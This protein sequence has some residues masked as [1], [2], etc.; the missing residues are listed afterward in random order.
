MTSPQPR[1]SVIIPAY[2]VQPY[3]AEAVDSALGQSYHDVDVVVVD[4]GSTDG[5]VRVLAQYG[6]GIT[7]V[8]Q[9]NRGLPAARN[10]GIRASTG[11]VVALLDGDDTWL[12]ERVERCV[13]V[14]L[15]R[16]DVGF[17]TTDASLIDA[18][19]ADLGETYCDQVPFP[20]VRF[21]E[22]MVRQNMVYGSPLVRRSVFDAAGPF[23]ETLTSGGED[24]DMWLRLVAAGVAMVTIP[25]PL[26]CYRI[27]RSS[28]TRRD[29]GLTEPRS[30]VL[31]RHLPGFWRRGVYGSSNEAFR[32][33]A[34]LALHGEWKR[35]AEFARAAFRDP[36]RNALEVV[37]AAARSTTR[38]VGSVVARC[39]SGC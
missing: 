20:R 19:G 7:L 6:D 35:S 12:P 4:D 24:Y 9:P 3:I 33:A 5:T 31:E 25:E 22:A 17:V 26:A 32:I 2:N 28:L 27:R 11:D 18:R 1:V 16:P 34:R 14:L 36:E 29:G 21:A 13:E 39:V 38:E 8:T 23:D 30:R 37:G 15:E 10:A